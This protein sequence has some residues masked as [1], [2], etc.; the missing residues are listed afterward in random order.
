MAQLHYPQSHY[1]AQQQ[2]QQ[3]QQP[4][5]IRQLLQSRSQHA[6]ALGPPSTSR[7]SSYTDVSV[8]D[9][10]S[11]YSRGEF[12]PPMQWQTSFQPHR[13]PPA[14]F[15]P[16]HAHPRMQHPSRR[17]DTASTFDSALSFS[18]DASGVESLYSASHALN[19]LLPSI[20]EPQQ[21]EYVVHRERVELS[22][23]AERRQERAVPTHVGS[24]WFEE[25]TEEEDADE[26]STASHASAT[27]CTLAEKV[28]LLPQTPIALNFPTVPAVHR[29][30][31]PA[32]PSPSP[33]REKSLPASPR[34]PPSPR[35][36]QVNS[37]SLTQ[38]SP[39]LSASHPSAPLAS[40]LSYTGPKM[41]FLSPAPW[42]EEEEYDAE[43]AL[44][45]LE[46]GREQR[47][48]KVSEDRASGSGKGKLKQLGMGNL[49][50]ESL[51][52]ERDRA[53]L[54]GL[55]LISP[56]KGSSAH[57]TSSG[58]SQS[59]GSAQPALVVKQQV[60]GRS[61]SRPPSP[62]LVIPATVPVAPPPPPTPSTATAPPGKKSVGHKFSLP[63]L[64]HA[65]QPQP[66][67]GP[68]PNGKPPPIPSPSTA[69]FTSSLPSPSPLET[70]FPRTPTSA[71]NTSL[72][73]HPYS[74]QS[75][76]G[77]SSAERQRSI[78]EKRSATMPEQ[79]GAGITLISLE[80]ARVMA[81]QPHPHAQQS[82]Q[83]SLPTPRLSSNE[84]LAATAGGANGKDKDK[85]LKG[86]RSFLRL[87]NS[88]NLPGAP[89]GRES[90]EVHREDFVP[91]VPAL[92]A[93]YLA[94]P[95]PAMTASAGS[96]P[97]NSPPQAIGQQSLRERRQAVRPSPPLE[98]NVMISRASSS[99]PTMAATAAAGGG[100]QPLASAPP[101]QSAFLS[102]SASGLDVPK[103]PRTPAP[104][105]LTLRPVSTAFSAG[106]ASLLVDGVQNSNSPAKLRQV[107]EEP[108]DPER[109]AYTKSAPASTTTSPILRSSPPRSA[110]AR[111]R[112]KSQSAE[113]VI[114]SLQGQ[115]VASKR[116]WA[117]R[118]EELEFEV[119]GLRTEV[120]RLEGL[121]RNDSHVC[122]RCGGAL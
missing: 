60:R 58:S 77:K 26:E 67:P 43:D 98:V 99:D 87:F 84:N 120:G 104:P 28:S 111:Q 92:P 12:S 68:G 65:F 40:H 57:T 66:P 50:K 8:D 116:A 103:T 39:N 31:P 122:D 25:E 119:Q 38:A 41:T 21:P 75:P 2:Q 23:V 5:T 96:S 4:P 33:G 6:T 93:A 51:S 74:A 34:P 90:K 22:P 105:P 32:P 76:R 45:I 88:P 113:D 81:G 73:L 61:R 101:G 109:P 82:R 70:D 108:E 115:I 107:E 91:P 24:G 36:P 56:A 35:S 37:P 64:R 71:S 118:V 15:H 97:Q 52:Q 13:Q 46:K 29:K 69:S 85:V 110:S 47:P 72:G 83:Q 117:R 7:D 54:K 79:G 17:P 48:R 55:G 18:S 44:A 42:E 89:F 27:V 121:V 86:K 30:P 49:K 3:V 78:E 114:A 80:Q 1:H 112:E 14:H 62:V 10:P 95:S 100:L 106:F 59:G 102:G 94:L 20:T 16:Q 19:G 9:S 53:E 63:R 11:L